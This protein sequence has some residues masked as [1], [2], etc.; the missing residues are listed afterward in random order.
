[1]LRFAF[2]A[3][4]AFVTFAAPAQAQCAAIFSDVAESARAT[5]YA[6]DQGNRISGPDRPQRATSAL[7]NSARGLSEALDDAADQTANAGY[8]R[9]SNSDYPEE[10]DWLELLS[11]LSSDL[12]AILP[13]LR[14]SAPV[15]PETRAE[16]RRIAVSA[17]TLGRGLC[18]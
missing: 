17:A 18:N 8:N 1:M 16:L 10:E 14:L 2:I 6:I 12:D 5:R 7:I 15:A 9:P 11:Q 13:Q 3:A 4:L